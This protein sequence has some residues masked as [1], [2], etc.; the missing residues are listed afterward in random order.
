MTI[1][2][3][4]AVWGGWRTQRA[5][6]VG[7]AS[8]VLVVA[9]LVGRAAPAWAH[10]ELV[11]TSPAS[12]AV[13]DR[14]PEAIEL[15]FTEPVDPA[16]GGV[17]L[18]RGDGTTVGDGDG[19][20]GRVDG[21]GSTVRVGLDP[22]DLGEGTY[23]VVWRVT[24][25]D[26]HPVR[27]AFTFHIGAP[28]AQADTAALLSRVLADEGGTPATGAVLAIGR[29]ASF[30]G[31]VL[32]A[33]WALFALLGL[34]AV[35]P[36][37]G[38]V[39]VGGLV[40]WAALLGVVGTFVMFAGQA[41]SRT[42]QWSALVRPAAHLDVWATESGRW[43]AIRLLVLAVVG[44]GA[45]IG[46]RRRAVLPAPA[47]SGAAVSVAL[48]VVTAL[49]GHAVS[50][51][52]PAAGLV[53]TAAHLLALGV[54]MA[55]LVTLASLARRS[56]SHDGA[57][58]LAAFAPRFS[59]WAVLAVI[60]LVASGLVNSARQVAEVGLL[61]STD[62]GR[63]LIAKLIVVAVLLVVAGTSRRRTRRGDVAGVRRP[64]QLEVALAAVA[65]V[66]AALVVGQRPA[67]AE[68]SRLAS[69][70]A[71]VGA[72]TAEVVF[73]PARTGGTEVHVYLTSPGG[74]L[75]RARDIVVTA[76]LAAADVGPLTLPLY[77]AGPNHVTGPAVDLPLPGAWT[78]EISA[79]YGQFEEV[80]WRTSV[81]VPR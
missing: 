25:A 76:T 47:L 18:V 34:R 67:I 7:V 61:T 43:W 30:A 75:D 4:I 15:R 63:L 46:A 35:G 51:R 2:V 42:G 26:S 21:D 49:G 5:V 69:A 40:G 9:L 8:V 62:Y 48:V 60:G 13:V 65:L 1:A 6:R 19:D 70:F 57:A 11:S 52:W 81:D 14:A 27:G 16:P 29:W 3:G 80:R 41:V 24:S 50:G 68:Q 58:A 20:V 79:R 45:A 36:R 38:G 28:G 23:V 39:G 73:D 71:V 59:Y 54:W 44:A 10:A 55:G 17:R 64:V 77:D 74:S 53:A 66:V 22:D 32:C 31:V 72:R 33:G 78:I 37:G 12:G 56:R